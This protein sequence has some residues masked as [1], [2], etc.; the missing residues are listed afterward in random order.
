MQKPFSAGILLAIALLF[1]DRLPAHC[2][3]L[4]GPVVTAA[5]QAL[6]TGRVWHVLRWVRK[7]D[8]NEIRQA[9][10]RTVAVR[11]LSPAAKDLA[12]LY[13]FETVVRVHRTGEGA[14]YSGLKPA[15]RDLG[16]AIPAADAAISTGKPDALLKLMVDSVHA[17]VHDRYQAV[18]E[19]KAA[20]AE[21]VEAGRRYVAAYVRYVHFVEGVW[22]AVNAAPEHRHANPA[23]HHEH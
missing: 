3:G 22:Q 17:G 4:D 15:G 5:R 20:P 16:P 2:D 11:K 13:F 8:E 23:E 7:D 14:P 10:D 9:F 18:M 1:P 21:D 19:G 6:E 12:D